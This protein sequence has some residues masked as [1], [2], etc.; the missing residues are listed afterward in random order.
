MTLSPKRSIPVWQLVLIT[1]LCVMLTSLMYLMGVFNKPKNV[2]MVTFRVEASGGFANITYSDA[3]AQVLDSKTVS[4]PWQRTQQN[5]NGTQVLLTATN[6]SQ[7]GTL[8]CELLLDNKPWKKETASKGVD[9]VA[10]GG[11]VP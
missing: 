7:S 6:P 8:S 4:T 10:C 9:A 3:V 2:H 5:P 1:V 11:I